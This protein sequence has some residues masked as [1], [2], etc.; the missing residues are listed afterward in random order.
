MLE[1]LVTGADHRAELE[2]IGYF[3]HGSS[4]DYRWQWQKPPYPAAVRGI[5]TA[6]TIGGALLLTAGTVAVALAAW[7]IIT[8]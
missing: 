4:G 3:K 5:G 1:C 6:I 2:A 8:L 7:G